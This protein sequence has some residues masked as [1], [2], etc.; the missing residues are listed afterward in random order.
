MAKCACGLVF[1]GPWDM[2]AH[3]LAVY[4]PSADQPADDKTHADVTPLSVKLAEGPSE[5]WTISVWARD[6]KKYFRVAASI[7]MRSATDDLRESEEIGHQWI[8]GTYQVSTYAARSA[9]QI[10]K[11]EGV[12]GNFGGSLNP[13][14]RDWVSVRNSRQRAARILDLIA[15]HVM[16]LEIKFSTLSRSDPKEGR[17]QLIKLDLFGDCYQAMSWK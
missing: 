1:P 12:V 14:P 13:V 2:I 9:I 10:L 5:G 4:P 16:N 8:R 3:F 17:T 15:I 6:P 7:A 11:E